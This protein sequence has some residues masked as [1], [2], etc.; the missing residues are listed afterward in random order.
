MF[1]P[2]SFPLVQRSSLHSMLTDEVPSEL[3]GQSIFDD[4]LI[5]NRQ[6]LKF[7]LYEM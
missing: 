5:L 4:N 3:F 6:F 1:T 2:P 7:K